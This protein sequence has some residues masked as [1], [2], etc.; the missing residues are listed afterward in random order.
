MKGSFNIP[1]LAAI[2][3]LGCA[4]ASGTTV[5]SPAEETLCVHV[6]NLAAVAPQTM[7]WARS[8]TTRIFIRA[9]IGISWEQPP[10]ASPEARLWDLNISPVLLSRSRERSCLVVSVL[11][12]L[13]SAAYPGA[14]GFALPFARSGVSAEIIYRRVELL[15]ASVGV[16]PEVLLAYT[17]AHEM[18]HVL[19]RSSNHAPAGIMQGHWNAGNWRLASFGMMNFL[20]QEAKQMRQGLRRFDPQE[21]KNPT[22]PNP[23]RN[24]MLAASRVSTKR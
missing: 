21:P 14:L 16:A 19:L 18:G 6:Y 2:F 15:A 23:D 3:T 4:V 7:K 17:M 1:R 22:E 12:D 13:S 5:E 10:L 11:Q 9:G 20:P 8:E 24:S